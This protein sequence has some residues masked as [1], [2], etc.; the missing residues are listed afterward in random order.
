MTDVRKRP[1]LMLCRTDIIKI[2]III[3][4]KSDKMVYGNSD[5]AEFIIGID[6]LT[7]MQQVCNKSL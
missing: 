5:I 1:W 6:P 2:Y 3:I 4:C 7:Y